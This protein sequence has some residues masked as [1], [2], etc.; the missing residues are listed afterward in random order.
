MLISVHINNINKITH[1]SARI[2]K[3]N[4]IYNCIESVKL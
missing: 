1:I 2:I 3:Y 4:Y